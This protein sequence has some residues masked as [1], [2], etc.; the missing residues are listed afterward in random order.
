MKREEIRNHLM[1]L[2]DGTLLPERA[3]EVEEA[4]AQH[5]DLEQELGDLREAVHLAG[6]LS[7]VEVPPDLTEGIR[8]AVNTARKPVFSPVRL[9]WPVAAAAAALLLFAVALTFRDKG[10]DPAPSRDRVASK[11]TDAFRKD[12]KY[13]GDAEPTIAL[14]KKEAAEDLI[15]KEEKKKEKRIK[16]EESEDAAPRQLR[17]RKERERTRPAPSLGGAARSSGRGSGNR[18]DGQTT[19]PGKPEAATADKIQDRKALKKQVSRIA[20]QAK[21][22]PRSPESPRP[23]Q[24]RRGSRPEIPVGTRPYSS[25]VPPRLV[26]ARLEVEASGLVPVREALIRFVLASGIKAASIPAGRHPAAEGRGGA[27]PTAGIRLELSDT[28][29][30]RLTALLARRGNFSRAPLV[31]RKW[32]KDLAKG[33]LDDGRGQEERLAREPAPPDRPAG[34]ARRL[35]HSKKP[36]ADSEDAPLPAGSRASRK[37]RRPA[38]ESKD[39]DKTRSEKKDPRSSRGDPERMDKAAHTTKDRPPRPSRQ[40]WFLVIRSK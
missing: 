4:L 2:V 15:C 39:Q 24:V 18:R 5:P 40:V 25:P 19:P 10:L 1:D 31:A 29:A 14:A 21:G 34:V 6:Q 35:A 38:A 16:S 28:E 20:N 30:K 11:K 23:R 12:F 37:E 33:Y 36:G 27:F 9:L 32:G 13:A 17:P 7:V 8:R 22:Q 3:R 26:K